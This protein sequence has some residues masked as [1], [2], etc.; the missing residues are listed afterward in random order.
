MG[1]KKKFIQYQKT[2]NILRGS[3]TVFWDENAAVAKDTDRSEKEERFI[4]IGFNSLAR[5]LLVCFCEKD[6]SETIRIFSARKLTKREIKQF[7]RRWR[8]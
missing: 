7:N 8:K 2:Q 4:I 3:Q 6:G 1:P 5:P